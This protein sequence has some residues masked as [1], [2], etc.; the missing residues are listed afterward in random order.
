MSLPDQQPD[1]ESYSLAELHDIRQHLDAHTYPDRA[2]IV[3]RLIA[4]KEATGVHETPP[5]PPF[6]YPVLL[7]LLGLAAIAGA[8]F[9]RGGK[10]ALITALVVFL[11]VGVDLAFLGYLNGSLRRR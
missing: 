10:A 8:W 1:F 3:Q 6:W 9:S 11:W 2:A 7:S 4:E 5:D